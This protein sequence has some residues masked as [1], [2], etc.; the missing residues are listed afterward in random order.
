MN[1]YGSIA[2]FYDRWL[3]VAGFKRGVEQFLDR[4]E[5]ILPAR[6]RVLD[7]G[8]GTG[9]ISLW[10]LRRFPDAHVTAFDIDRKML[11]VAARRARRIA[12]ARGRL[13]LAEGDLTAPRRLR[14][15]RGEAILLPEASFDLIVIGAALEHVPLA[16]T[17]TGL[18]ALLKPGGLFVNLGVRD[19]SAAVVLGAVYQFRPYRTGEL[20]EA[21]R[22]AGFAQASVAPLALRDFPANLTRIAVSAVKP[23]AAA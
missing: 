18:H 8:C 7:G 20:L 1:P 2:G 6:P 12:G 9:L 3:R 17:L 23:R 13:T 16:S 10:L 15:A 22:G 5:L 19:A 21:L 14:G 11:A 4:M